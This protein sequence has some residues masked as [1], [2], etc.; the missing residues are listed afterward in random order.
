MRD[1]LI[2]TKARQLSK[3]GWSN[4]AVASELGVKSSTISRWC[5]QIESP[6][7]KGI[8]DYYQNQRNKFFSM[9][10]LTVAEI[11]PKS[12][13]LYTALLY[14]CEGSKYPADSRVC[15]TTSD[16]E[17]Q[18]LFIALLRKGF[19]LDESK[20]R[21]WLQIH[22]DQN[23]N[24]IFSYWSNILKIPETQF[25]KPRITQKRGG[26]YR[27]VYYGTCTL[28]YHDYSLLLRLMGIYQRFTKDAFYSLA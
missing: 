6:R 8:I 12:A 19:K 22:T 4:R 2:V 18:R 27:N 26:R 7:V 1:E 3:L 14:W 13:K 15:F 17:M 9:D 11:S 21:I 10:H 28:R 16:V 23:K 24:H 20:F 25:I 5:A